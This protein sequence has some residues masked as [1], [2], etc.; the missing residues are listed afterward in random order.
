MRIVE[1]SYEILTDI[2]E[3]GEK[4]L[5]FIEKVARTCYKSEPKTGT[6]E[7][8]KLFVKGLIDRGHLAMIEHSMLSVK[9]IC[10]R[11]IS[12]EIVRHRLAS[13]AQESTRWC[14]YSKDRFNGI[15]VIRPDF[16]NLKLSKEGED[17]LYYVW[18]KQCEQAEELYLKMT[19][20]G[21]ISP[22]QSRSILPTCLKTELVM[23][24]NYRE[25]RHFFK[26]RTAKDAHP[27]VRALSSA[28]LKEL[29]NRIPIIFDD[30]GV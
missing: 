1:P 14:N 28:L 13:F 8:T 12:H 27:Q 3:N 19:E 5:R 9:F 29:Q 6:F 17:T 10:D 23:T 30:L 16:S 25:W 26:L 15:G 24:T 4:E 2:S 22:Q 20:N 21:T 18:Q 7:E 11:G